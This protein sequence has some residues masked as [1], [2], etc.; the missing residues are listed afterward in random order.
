MTASHVAVVGAG[1]FGVTAALTLRARGHAV[2]LVDPGPIP[3]PLAESTDISKAVRMDYGADETYTAEMEIALEGWRAWNTAWGT[4]LFHEAGVTYLCKG[5]M[6]PGGFEHDSYGVLRRRGHRPERLD[7]GAIR[8]RFPAWNAD[9]YTDGYF[10]RH[11]GYA[12]SGKVVTALARQ[13][14]ADGVVLRTGFRFARLLERGSRVVGIG[15]AAGAEIHADHVV[16][17]TGAW[18]PHALPY[19]APHLR[20]VGQPVFH[21][22]PQDA[23]PFRAMCFPTFGADIARTGYYGFPANAQ[24]IVKIA[25]H[26][27]GRA[28]A[29][30]SAEREVTATDEQN[31][32]A[33]LRESFPLLEKAP[34]VHT[35][36]CVY[37]DTWDEHFWIAKD[38]DR[39]GLVVAAGGSGHAFKFAPRLGPWIA[40]ALEGAKNPLLDKFRWRTDVRPA[41]GEEAARHHG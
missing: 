21:L 34:I 2:T 23:A 25:N 16:M 11:G 28:I 31:L 26:G 37:G 13:A 32:R 20:C 38:P 14:G 15:D 18:T 29:P 35:R 1:I 3:H 7:A 4:P 22:A 9:V 24:G 12:E 40:D 36:I 30:D 33:F 39:A 27:P 17:A 41:Q 10:N 6:R 8:A 19:L 5:P